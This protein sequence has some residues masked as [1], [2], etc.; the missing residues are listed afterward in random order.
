MLNYKNHTGLNF[1][2]QYLGY[3]F[4]VH[5]ILKNNNF[6]CWWNR[7]ALPDK[8]FTRHISRNFGFFV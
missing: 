2:D 1:Y 4:N 3:S 7:K 6:I 8:N 5:P